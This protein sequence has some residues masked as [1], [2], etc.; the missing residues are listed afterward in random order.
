MKDNL[1]ALG[2]LLFALLLQGALS[3][4]IPISA[5]VDLPLV[6]ATWFALSRGE[7][8]G[9]VGASLSGWLSEALFGRGIRGV[10]GLIRLVL[11][12]ALGLLG[13]RFLI[14]GAL[15]RFFLLLTVTVIDTRAYEW[16]A[17][18]FGM[19]PVQYSPGAMTIRGTINA[20]VG[21]VLFAL[22]ERRQARPA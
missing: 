22:F 9:M 18:A 17:P 20:A 12:F 19:S 21:L 3:L 6:V 16:I 15:P 13:S 11:G 7:L 14:T 4:F 2:L 5:Y 8:H 10:S 1:I